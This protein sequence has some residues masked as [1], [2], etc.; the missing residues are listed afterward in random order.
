MTH[1]SNR[2]SAHSSA[3]IA[4]RLL[5]LS[6]PAGVFAFLLASWP[7]AVDGGFGAPDAADGSIVRTSLTAAFA[8]TGQDR[9]AQATPAVAA[10]SDAI[11][12]AAK[13]GKLADVD[14]ALRSIPDGR[15]VADVER[16]RSL[17][18]ERFSHAERSQTD[19]TKDL[20]AAAKE[21]SEKFAAG[22]ITKALTAAVR[23]QT[24]SDD[25]KAVLG[26]EDIQK[27]I[28]ASIEADA[29]AQTEGDW[30]LSQEILFR[31]RTLY[32]D[33]GDRPTFK[34][35]ADA[36]ERVNRRIG[37]LAQY[38]P[39]Q[40]HDLRRKAAERAGPEVLEKFPAWNPAFADEWKDQVRDITRPMLSAGLKRAAEDHISARGW[41]PLVDGGID[42][43]M[44]VATTDGLGETF[45][46]LGDAKKVAQFTAAVEAARQKLPQH[47]EEIGRAEYNEVLGAVIAA[48]DA[49]IKLPDAVLLHEFGDGAIDEL[50]SRYE[51]QYTEIIWPERL[52]RFQQQVDGDF[53]GVGILIR[54]DDKRDIV[55]VNPLEGSPAARGGIK[56]E[57]RIAGVN[58]SPSVGWSL[59]KAVDSITGPAGQNVTLTIRRP[60]VEEPFD[61]VLVRD[62]IKMRSVNGWWKKG[63]DTNGA[64]E[65]TWFIDEPSGIGYVRLTSF[66]EDSFEDFRA[67][68]GQMRAERPLNGLILDIRHNPGGLLK[69]AVDFTNIFVPSGTVV[70]GED[71]NDRE[72]FNL[73]AQPQRAE[74][75]GLPLVVL[76]NQG[77]ASASEIVSGALQAH[78]AAVVI[79]ERSFGKGSV[80]TVHDI[81]DR[82]ASAAIKLTTQ[83][84]V[85]P[86]LPGE[87]HG[88]LVH[89]VPGA[90]DWGVNPDL[91]VKMTPEQIEKSLE[92]RQQADIIEEWKDEKDRTPRPDPKELLT[93]N[94]DPQLEMALLIL[95][96]RALKELDASA[97]AA[98]PAAR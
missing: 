74:L 57:D 46:G 61:V 6:I 54:H 89:R 77:S 15:A 14:A 69:S 24:L 10:W 87:Q 67:A 84:Y 4:R 42:A 30:L 59:N 5:P 43:M 12:Q 38:A 45:E 83:H 50:G 64:P 9:T 28:A 76:I 98:A 88:R 72:V 91:Q 19:R 27:L 31:L 49:S 90:E 40:L 65:W 97:M 47:E 29:K 66:N 26:R 41:A 58:G 1:R 79:G 48:N 78:D 17:A 32:E 75:Q 33:A 25:W 63:L 13:D 56:A 7:T 71:R 95:K 60:G 34:R 70:S 62:R 55:V 11:W 44:I 86:P 93:K 85:L 37:L 52:R 68:I 3:T 80:Q 92:L 2:P 51:D 81:S 53:V 22:D 73:K 39:K 18:N 94:L 23:L 36:L 82:N 21:L 16:L 35:Y 8:G 20:E 96:A